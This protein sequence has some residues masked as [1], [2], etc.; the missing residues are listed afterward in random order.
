M[1]DENNQQVEQGSSAQ[2]G[3]QSQGD[4]DT[5][6]DVRLT[7]EAAKW[8]VRVR[9]LEAQL[10]ALKPKA[11]QFD[12]LQESQKT[13]AQKLTDRIAALEADLQT[14]A[15]AADRATKEAQLI[16][17]ATKA[18]VDPDVASLLDLSKIDL[19]DE[20]AA[21]EVLSKFA[22]PTANSAQVKPGA[23]GATGL[24]EAELHARY[25]GGSKPMI[26]GG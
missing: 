26:F 5:Q 18:G 21:I 3:Q 14:K 24:T 9:D 23:V 7:A 11:E 25:F 4:A 6:Q 12:Q 10:T 8:R 19:S 13:E 17:I 22:K 2:Q 20:K 1:A 15:T 16:R